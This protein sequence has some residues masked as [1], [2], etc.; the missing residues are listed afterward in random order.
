MGTNSNHPN[1]FQAGN[2]ASRGFGPPVGNVN[3]F[4]SGRKSRR[5]L[6]VGALPRGCSWINSLVGNFRRELER[7]VCD[8][9]GVV[10]Y[11][12]ALIVQSAA[13][14]E[15]AALLAQRWLRLS[16]DSMTHLER[17]SYIQAIAAE[18]DKRDKAIEKLK[19]DTDPQTIVSSLYGPILPPDD[20]DTP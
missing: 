20:G 1:L 6:T 2:T 11:K 5:R 7:C 3:G 14:H 10:D 9:H 16:A 17:L 4:K 18:S 8:A 13:R 12:A 15:Q 19:L